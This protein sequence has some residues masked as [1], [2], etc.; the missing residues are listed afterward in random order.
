MNEITA[1]T[2][3]INQYDHPRLGLLRKGDVLRICPPHQTGGKVRLFDHEFVI[4]GFS[5]TTPEVLRVTH[6]LGGNE[7][8]NGIRLDLEQLTDRAQTI[9]P[10]LVLTGDELYASRPVYL[11]RAMT[12]NHYGEALC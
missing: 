1:N 3:L 9:D 6:L 2:G 10:S 12:G 4:E 7:Q 5:P 8:G 11:D